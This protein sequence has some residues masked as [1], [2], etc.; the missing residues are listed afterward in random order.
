MKLLPAIIIS[1]GQCAFCQL[2]IAEET[3]RNNDVVIFKGYVKH[4]E[5]MGQFVNWRN[6]VVDGELKIYGHTVQ[7]VGLSPRSL[8]ESLAELLGPDLGTR[9]SAVT[10]EVM[11]SD[12]YEDN[13]IDL[14]KE[15]VLMRKAIERCERRIE[16]Y[17][18]RQK[19]VAAAA[20]DTLFDPAPGSNRTQV[21]SP[22]PGA[23]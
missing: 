1:M 17:R 2:A 12:E 20:H 5:D 21:P 8:Y 15:G 9:L 3:I 22:A 16:E 19:N 13:R 10:V 6:R 18:E 11:S 14:C 23:N 7:A 4:C